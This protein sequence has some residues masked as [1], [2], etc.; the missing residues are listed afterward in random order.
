MLIFNN[1]NKKSLNSFPPRK[2]NNS[3][4]ILNDSKEKKLIQNSKKNNYIK[5]KFG[6]NKRKNIKNKKEGKN[7]LIFDEDEN[8]GN[9]K[10]K[11]RF[12]EDDN[13]KFDNIFNNNNKNL[14]KLKVPSSNNLENI[15][16]KN[17]KVLFLL[18]IL[19]LQLISKHLS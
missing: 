19:G 16:R 1:R 13:F 10:R 18:I 11:L 3:T 2:N 7:E 8:E 12:M 15:Q 14:L 5:S 4:N 9:S 6:N 17:E